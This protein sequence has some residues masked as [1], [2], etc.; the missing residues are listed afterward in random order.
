MIV[1]CPQ[2][3]TGYN[4]PDHIL[5]DKPRKMRCAKCQNMFTVVKRSDHVPDGYTEFTG[6]QQL[7]AE[8]A[9][10]KATEPG[11]PEAKKIV[12]LD[13]DEDTSVGPPPRPQGAAVA[14]QSRAAVQP[15]GTAPEAPVAPKAPVQQAGEPAAEPEKKNEPAKPEPRGGSIPVG[16]SIP[17]ESMFGNTTSA[18]EIEAPLELGTYTISE[19]PPPKGQTA[20]KIVF[21]IG[22]MLIGFFIFV[23]YRN[24]WSLSLFELPEQ[25]AFALSDEPTEQLPSSVKNIDTTM[26]DKKI[27]LS[28]KDIPYLV[29]SGEVVNNNP[30]TRQHII[31]RGKLYDGEG[32]MRMEARMPC[33]RIVEEKTLK[34]TPQ[35]AVTGHFATDGTLFNCSISPNDST[36][37]QVIFEKLPPDYNALFTVKL[38]AVAATSG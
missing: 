32:K 17:A 5:T 3:S 25:V 23:A 38:Q 2:C 16:N 33:G 10:L 9:F 28:D 37:F 8:F 18:W 24:S 20:G 27:V 31:I 34:L 19:A 13:S 7:P 30:G 29:V 36:V 14:Q 35:D 21:F 4:I 6:A 12:K 15:S 1:K 26:L 11:P 22:I